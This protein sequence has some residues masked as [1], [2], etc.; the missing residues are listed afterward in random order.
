M[1]RRSGSLGL[2]GIIVIGGALY[3][4][5]AGNWLWQQV[6]SLDRACYGLLSE[7]GTTMGSPV[8]DGIG[9]ATAYIGSAAN[10]A[11]YWVRGKVD[12][13]RSGEATQLENYAEQMFFRISAE[14]PLARIASPGR[15]LQAMM[16]DEP[17]LQ[18]AAASASEKMRVAIDQFVIG[19]HY[20]QQNATAQALPWLRQS[21]QQPSGYGV[22]SQLTLGDMYRTGQGVPVSN[23]IA[24][25]YYEQAY[26]SI[27]ALQSS[28]GDSAKAMLRGLPNTPPVVM[29]QLEQRMAELK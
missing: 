11:T 25:Q 29:K 27:T 23:S 21:A 14:S 12:S 8:C 20:L 18:N 22:L 6:R 1:A 17:Q 15:Q 2:I 4:S 26:Q 19:Q 7:I 28:G 3:Y 24:R 9:T 5:G 16:R 10:D 13:F